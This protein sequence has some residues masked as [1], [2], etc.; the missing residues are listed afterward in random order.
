MIPQKHELG[1]CPLCKGSG[2]RKES[3]F[4]K[5][6]C[7]CEETGNKY[8]IFVP[9]PNKL[10]NNFSA[11]FIVDYQ[12]KTLIDK[13]H[14]HFD[15]GKV[16]YQGYEHTLYINGL[17]RLEPFYALKDYNLDHYEFPP[18]DDPLFPFER[19]KNKF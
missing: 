13:I 9:T 11:W 3:D 12:D 6:D 19:Y 14:K 7:I 16:R 18:T 5:T 1:L 2:F 10:T 17:Y 4:T 8:F 15:Y